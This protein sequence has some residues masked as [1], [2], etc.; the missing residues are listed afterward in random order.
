MPIETDSSQKHLL[1][2]EEQLLMK[3][4]AV[5]PKVSRTRKALIALGTSLAFLGAYSAAAADTQPMMPTVVNANML[6]QAP[7]P[8]CTFNDGDLI[9]VQADTGKLL[10]RCNGC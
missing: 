5:A 9:T 8:A 4:E 2:K 10:A 6:Q 3:D 7:S 1:V